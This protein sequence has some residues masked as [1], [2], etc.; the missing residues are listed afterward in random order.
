[1]R[2]LVIGGNGTIGKKV[3]SFLSKKNEVITAGRKSGDLKIDLSDSNS[4]KSL[5]ETNKKFDSV[6][7]IAGEAIWAPFE[8]ITEDQ[9]YIGIKN[10][11]MGQ[12]NLVRIGWKYIKKGGSITLTTGILADNPVKMTTSAALVNGGIH[13]F[14]KAAILEIKNNIRVN[15]ISPGLVEDSAEKYKDYFPGFNIV[16]MK[17]LAETY[18]KVLYGNQNGEIIR[19]FS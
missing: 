1:M 8:R 6:I 9:Y 14:V 4:I 17:K 11:M 18:A 10:K 12:V 19:I 16:A 7:S 3:S 5:F 15:V 13:S 2:I